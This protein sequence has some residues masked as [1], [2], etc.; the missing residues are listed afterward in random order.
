MA[1]SSTQI[2]LGTI[3]GRF[4]HAETKA[5]F[6]WMDFSGDFDWCEGHDFPHEIFVG[7]ARGDE[8]RRARVLKTVAYVVVDE[9]EYGN[10]VVEKWQIR[11]EWRRG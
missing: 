3:R 9:D 7:G 2:D 5:T 8:T 1:F 6:E 10:P 11:E 4:S